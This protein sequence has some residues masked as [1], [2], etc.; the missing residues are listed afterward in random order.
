VALD[1][2]WGFGLGGGHSWIIWLREIEEGK[3]GKEGKEMQ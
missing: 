2:S 1:A 3:E